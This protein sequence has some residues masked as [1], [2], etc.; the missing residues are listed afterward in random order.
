MAPTIA[1]LKKAFVRDLADR[2]VQRQSIRKAERLFDE[3]LA[4][5]LGVRTIAEVDSD[6]LVVRLGAYLA[7]K[8]FAPKSQNTWQKALNTVRVFGVKYGYLSLRPAPLRDPSHPEW[9]TENGT[10]EVGAVLS[11]R[12]L[13]HLI[14]Q[15]VQ[16]S[17]S[18][19]GGRDYLMLGLAALHGV[20]PISAIGLRIEHVAA[21]C[22]SITLPGRTGL[23][24][25]TV[26]LGPELSGFLLAWIRQPRVVETGA[27]FPG[28]LK[29]LWSYH[30]WY[31]DRPSV[32]LRSLCKR[33][34]IRPT[35][36][37]DVLRFHKANV[38]SQIPVIAT[39]R[40][41]DT[42]RRERSIVLGEPSER[43]IVFGVDQGVLPRAQ[44]AVLKTIVDAGINGV[45]VSEIA[46][47]SG[48][49]RAPKIVKAIKA[50]SP[51]FEDLIERPGRGYAGQQGRYRISA[52]W[53]DERRSQAEVTSSN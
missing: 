36:F 15:A 1:D 40:G 7:S 2:K 14:Q 51:E 16:E 5:G 23:R 27:L 46:A 44:H 9:I 52:W 24:P 31:N 47:K 12:E 19:A 4:Q 45:L 20:K 28:R 33:A 49:G 43:V 17:G 41:V 30:S 53:S 32:R 3:M 13:S 42:P 50:R 29:G 10:A 35:T 6:D 8:G 34:G 18:L 26:K 39:P 37:S 21:D 48:H 11:G 22:A 25:K 38:V